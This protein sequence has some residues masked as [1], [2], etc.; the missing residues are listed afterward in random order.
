MIF[1]DF[2]LDFPNCFT[3]LHEVGPKLL[4]YPQLFFIPTI[5]VS[6]PFPLFLDILPDY[7][8][9]IISGTFDWVQNYLRTLLCPVLKIMTDR[10]G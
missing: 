4:L 5:E 6:K 9:P 1:Y 2:L 7:A 8:A 10:Q 3:Q